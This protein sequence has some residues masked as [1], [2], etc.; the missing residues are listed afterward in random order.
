MVTRYPSPWA[1]EYLTG[2][3]EGQKAYSRTSKK[4]KGKNRNQKTKES[5]R[6]LAMLKGG[7]QEVKPVSDTGAVSSIKA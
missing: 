2:A 6:M 3:G 7:T 1:T 5:Q 4:C